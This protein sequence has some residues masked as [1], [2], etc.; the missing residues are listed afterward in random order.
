MPAVVRPPESIPPD[1]MSATTRSATKS[2]ESAAEVP[3]PGLDATVVTGDDF[4]AAGAVVDGDAADSPVA[5]LD[6]PED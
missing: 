3:L 1:T 2:A 6:E 4:E 5:S